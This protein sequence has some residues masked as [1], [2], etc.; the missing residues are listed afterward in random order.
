MSNGNSHSKPWRHRLSRWLIRYRWPLSAGLGL[1]LVWYA[2]CLPRPLFDAPLSLVLESRNGQLLNAQIAADEQWRFPPPDSIPPTFEQALLAFEDQRF[3]YH[4]GVDPISIGRALVQN[5][6]AGEVV[7]GGSTLSMQVIRMA[8][9]NPPRTLLRKVQEALLATR[10]ELSYSKSDILRLYATHAPFG[11]NVVGLEAAT[12]RYFGKPP[13]LLSWSEAAMLAVL[14]NQPGLI[15]PGRNREALLRKRNRLLKR[16]HQ[17]AYLD[18]T[19]LEL[20]LAEPLPEKPLPL[21]QLTPHLMPRAGAEGK[22]SRLRTTVDAG[23]QQQVTQILQLHQARLRANQIHNMAALVLDVETGQALAY[24]GNVSGAGA[25][26]GEWVDV[27]P[28]PRSTGSILK[29]FLYAFALQEGVAAPGQLLP[30][31]PLQLSGYRPENFHED[32][33]GAVPAERALIR[34]LNVPMVHLLSEYG[35]EK[36]HYRL[37]QIGLTTLNHPASH[38]GLPLVLG[39]A[40]GSLWEIT[41][42]YASM[43]R[44]LNHT[45]DLNGQYRPDDFHAPTYLLPF[46]ADDRERPA[47]EVP[48]PMSAA[49]AW[50]TFRAMQQVE[51]PASE[52]GW[53]AF[54]S[55]RR[56]AWKTGTSFGFRDAWAIGLTSHYAVGVW[57][58]NADGEGRPGLIG[59]KAAA[60]AL[61][62][63][64][65]QLPADPEWF[66]KPWDD[67]APTTLCRQSGYQALPICPA[68]TVLLP[69]TAASLGPCPY[70]QWVHLD[71]SGQWQVHT[72]CYPHA[73]IRNSPWFVLPPTAE[74]YYKRRHPS[75]RP[76]PPFAP[77]CRGDEGTPMELIYPKYPARILVPRDLDGSRSRTVFTVAHRN[78]ATTIYWHLDEA[79]LGATQAFHSMELDPSPGPHQL[80]LIDEQGHRLQQIFEVGLQ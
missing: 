42:A 48:Q 6:R 37:Q 33:D 7:S 47:H 36:F 22:G 59:I 77:G 31:I 64:F 2:F 61:F 79:Y 34:S 70:H 28:A 41:G 68:D 13:A 65:K 26:H 80:T 45:Y 14:P 60:P 55:S 35:L 67:F 73:L 5:L 21:P 62:D 52:G 40:E 51:R 17:E 43:A 11:G 9:G 19:M 38:Y 66:G 75:Y 63:I 46:S 15:H 23:L 8:Q 74:H 49:A 78:P 16:L 1:F 30:D 24:V 25:D 71:S 58:G 32:F 12:W 56:I 57:A 4:P 76:L 54:Q 20:A 10:L 39:G 3:Y 27:I 50:L 69:R 29:P 53:K 72:A 44:M 18:S